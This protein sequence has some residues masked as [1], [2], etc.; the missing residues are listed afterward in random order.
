M[1]LKAVLDHLILLTSV[2]VQL[3]SRITHVY[4]TVHQQKVL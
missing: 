2:N 1:E 4:H 3:T